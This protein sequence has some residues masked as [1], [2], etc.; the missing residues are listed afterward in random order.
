[1]ALAPAYAYRWRMDSRKLLIVPIA[2][3]AMS[4]FATS[5][6]GAASESRSY[7]DCFFA[8]T[9]RDWRPLDN[10]HLILFANGRKPF[11]VELAAPAFGLS[12]EYKI[13][14]FDR[15]GRICPYGGDSIILE[16]P[17]RDRIPI[18]SIR[19]LSDTEFD[20]VLVEYGVKPPVIV[21]AESVEPDTSTDAR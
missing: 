17:V 1:M 8:R 5:A 15:D 3:L 14:V 11:L 18:R 7:N 9:L 21:D 16:G 10:E 6:S 2:V 19:R 4:G 13:G 20:E 12:F